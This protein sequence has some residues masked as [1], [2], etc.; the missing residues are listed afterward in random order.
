MKILTNELFHKFVAET[1]NRFEYLPELID[2]GEFLNQILYEECT[3]LESEGFFA[4]QIPMF[5]SGYFCRLHIGDIRRAFDNVFSNLRKYADPKIP[6]VITEKEQQNQI[7]VIIENYKS[8]QLLKTASHKIGLM[9][10]Q[11][12]VEQNGGSVNIEQDIT[13][14]SIEIFLPVMQVS[15]CNSNI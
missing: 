15:D 9:I 11:T 3:E 1:E 10:V 12:L 7:C 2:G 13:K 5:N 6:I 8:K 4:N 14:F